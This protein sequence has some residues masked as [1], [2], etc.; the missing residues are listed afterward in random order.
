MDSAVFKCQ[1]VTPMF[2]AGADPRGDPELRAPAIKGAMRWWFR[3][4]MGGLLGDHKERDLQELES[5][6]FGDTTQTSLV[7][8]QIL[9]G[10]LQMQDRARLPHKT[11]GQ[12]ACRKAIDVGS[13]FCIRLA[14]RVGRDALAFD[15]AKQSL[16][17]LLNLGGLGARSRRAFGSLSSVNGSSEEEIIVS[18]RDVF[19]RFLKA[20]GRTKGSWTATPPYPCIAEN[21]FDVW[22]ADAI[23]D[24]EAELKRLMNLMHVI[25]HSQH[26]NGLGGIVL[27]STHRL[28]S[29]LIVHAKKEHEHIRLV[30]SHF[31]TNPQ[32]SIRIMPVDHVAV[33]S[34]IGSGFGA[35]RL[36]VLGAP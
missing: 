10:H 9:D 25:S 35:R 23:G 3:A 19:E 20:S 27:R 21:Y 7:K 28:A 1:V 8:V 14:P 32:G 18:A 15:V 33:E 26:T 22:V 29:P 5:L 16:I 31:R 6:V 12:R 13:R 11:G 36:N 24:W 34:A 2:L 17:L 4:M 30:F